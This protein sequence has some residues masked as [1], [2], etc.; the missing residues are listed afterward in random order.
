MEQRYLVTWEMDIYA[1]SP[2]EAAE[3]AWGYM[4]AP[5]STANVFE[6]INKDGDR[7]IVDLLEEQQP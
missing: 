4:R 2:R 1:N 5:D 3:I 6:V 7:V